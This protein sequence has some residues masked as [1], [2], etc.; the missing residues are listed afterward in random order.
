MKYLK[1]YNLFIE[2]YEI[3]PSED[4]NIISNKNEINKLGEDLKELNSKKSQI[5]NIYLTYKDR[6]DLI[7]R[8]KTIGAIKEDN[9]ENIEFKNPLISNISNIYDL[10]RKIKDIE[11]SI[12]IDNQDMK[13]KQE[14]LSENPN[15]AENI[16]ELI[17]GIKERINEKN[18]KISDYKKELSEKE[19]NS[20]ENIDMLISKI[21]DLE[22]KI[23]TNKN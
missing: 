2:N 17:L 10:K 21:K 16:N 18:K 6:N 7:N 14:Q 19:K 15:Q 11:D 13:Q 20:K 23:S 5:E 12:N 8:L 3:N 9:P 4:T 1:R 22:V